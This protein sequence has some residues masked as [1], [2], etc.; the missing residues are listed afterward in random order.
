MIEPS[1]FLDGSF[2]LSRAYPWWFEY[3]GIMAYDWSTSIPRMWL[4]LA[5]TIAM[6]GQVQDSLLRSISL[7]LV[8]F[9]TMEQ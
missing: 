1:V 3:P 7:A 6:P 8:N 4:Q 5:P 9:A 2:E